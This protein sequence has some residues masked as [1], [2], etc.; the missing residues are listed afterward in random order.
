MANPGRP[1]IVRAQSS[2]TF[3]EVRGTPSDNSHTSPVGVIYPIFF[4]GCVA[5][6]ILLLYVRNQNAPHG[7]QQVV[8]T[9]DYNAALD[10]VPNIT[11]RLLSQASGAYTPKGATA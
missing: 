9:P 7:I 6:A 1:R 4:M 5:I 8:V 2:T 3:Y 10:L 11:Q